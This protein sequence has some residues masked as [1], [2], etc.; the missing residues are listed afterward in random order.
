MV[1][2]IVSDFMTEGV[3]KV[4]TLAMAEVVLYNKKDLQR[5]LDNEERQQGKENVIKKDSQIWSDE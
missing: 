3:K 5:Q 1:E 2:K 4:Y